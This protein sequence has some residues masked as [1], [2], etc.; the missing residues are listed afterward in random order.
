MGLGLGREAARGFV[1]AE[2]G[3]P[4]GGE[5][6]AVV[7]LL[8]EADEEAV[9]LLKGLE[10]ADDVG[11]RLARVAAEDLARVETHPARRDESAEEVFFYF[12]QPRLIHALMPPELNNRHLARASAPSR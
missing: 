8:G 2:V 10:G 9:L 3:G 11:V 6:N 1:E 4:V 12:R 5:L 7:A